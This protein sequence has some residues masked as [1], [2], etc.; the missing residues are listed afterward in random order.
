MDI[1]VNDLE[2]GKIDGGPV[3][4]P[5][6]GYTNG[7]CCGVWRDMCDVVLNMYCNNGHEYELRFSNAPD[8]TGTF[9]WT[10]KITAED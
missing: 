4:C 8:M 1:K 5:A 9:C 10:V 3:E 2:V 7:S 6:C